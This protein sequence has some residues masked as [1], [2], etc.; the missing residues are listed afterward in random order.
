MPKTAKST[1]PSDKT[2][3]KYGKEYAA[4]LEY[5]ADHIEEGT[6]GQACG[7]AC[8]A[9]ILPPDIYNAPQAH[10]TAVA[11]ALRK[12]AREIEDAPGDIEIGLLESHNTN[13]LTVAVF[14]D[15]LYTM[16]AVLA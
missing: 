4:K 12:L 15:V 11:T 10:L 16:R 5:A 8:A 7:K 14:R 13:G 6:S 9:V 3:V 2:V 1:V